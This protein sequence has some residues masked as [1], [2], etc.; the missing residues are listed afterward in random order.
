MLK[1]NCLSGLIFATVALGAGALQVQAAQ[2]VE[3]KR[4][5]CAANKGPGQ[6]M[7][8]CAAAR[9]MQAVKA[10]NGRIAKAA[11][12]HSVCGRLQTQLERDTCLNR[13]EATA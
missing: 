3:F 9:P 7:A 13:V 4:V 1:R 10:S 6:G 12:D 2:P 11:L 5:D 8:S